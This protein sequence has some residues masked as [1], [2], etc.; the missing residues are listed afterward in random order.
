MHTERCDRYAIRWPGAPTL[1]PP[2]TGPTGTNG[3]ANDGIGPLPSTSITCCDASQ[4]RNASESTVAMASCSA[5]Y[6]LSGSSSFIFP[7]SASS[8][9][10]VMSSGMMMLVILAEM[11]V[12]SGM[13]T[14]GM[15]GPIGPGKAAKAGY[16]GR[17]GT[18]TW[19][20]QSLK[21]LE[22][23]LATASRC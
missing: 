13:G 8:I 21:H 22:T 7:S 17:P 23:P 12:M 19:P 6:C 4:I 14:L 9:A 10:L 1:S 15:G 3:G 18:D 2:T 16:Q 11:Q 5:W 20:C